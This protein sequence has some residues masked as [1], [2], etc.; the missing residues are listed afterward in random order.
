[1]TPVGV[2]SWKNCPYASRIWFIAGL[3]GGGV[4]DS[5]AYSRARYF[6]ALLLA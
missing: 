3:P 6:M 5:S 1:M 2:I 4:F